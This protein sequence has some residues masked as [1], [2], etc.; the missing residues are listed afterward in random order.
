MLGVT[1]KI[2]PY[3]MVVAK[4][5]K[6]AKDLIGGKLAV[7]RLADV[8]AIASQVALVPLARLDRRSFAGSFGG[9]HNLSGCPEDLR[10]SRRRWSLISRFLSA[11]VFTY[12]LAPAR[13]AST[14]PAFFSRIM[15]CFNVSLRRSNVNLRQSSGGGRKALTVG[16]SPVFAKVPSFLYQRGNWIG[17]ICHFQF[18]NPLA[19]RPR[20]PSSTMPR[21][22]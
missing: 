5:I 8:S 20:G 22:I 6:S 13:T 12:R 21:M 10:S 16:W 19:A 17:D 2:F 3:T 4:N 1:S 7:N 15:L 14:A 9:G 18:L 11:E